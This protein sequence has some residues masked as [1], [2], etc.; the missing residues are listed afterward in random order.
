MTT[1]L[2]QFAKIVIDNIRDKQ[3]DYANI[4]LNNKSNTSDLK[5]LQKKLNKL[6]KEQK[7]SINELL[8]EITTNTMHDLLFAL[9][10]CHNTEGGIEIL[11][12]NKNIVDLSDGI[13]GEIFGKDGW[14]CRFSKVNS[15]K[16]IERSKIAQDWISREFS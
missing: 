5:L 16:E 12:N 1:E 7:K 6:D 15:E 10:D 3:I 11:V 9:Q 8:E 13:H 14:I 4:L 2:D